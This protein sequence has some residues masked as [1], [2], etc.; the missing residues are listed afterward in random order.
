MSTKIKRLEC[1]RCGHNWPPRIE[2]EDVK[3]CPKCMSPYWDSERKLKVK[4]QK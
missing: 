3:V 4:K 2:I 1:K